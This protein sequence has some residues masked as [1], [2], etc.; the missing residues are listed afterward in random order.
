ML[1]NKSQ[2]PTCL[3]DAGHNFS[4][5]SKCCLQLASSC[6]T[7]I[8]KIAH[9]LV[10]NLIK[11]R[12][13]KITYE[14][15]QDHR[16]Y[17][18]FGGRNKKLLRAKI[19]PEINSVKPLRGIERVI[20]SV[21]HGFLKVCHGAPSLWKTE[22]VLM[23]S[24]NTPLMCP[25]KAFFVNYSWASILTLHVLFFIPHCPLNRF[26]WNRI[27]CVQRWKRIYRPSRG[28]TWNNIYDV[29]NH[30]RHFGQLSW[31]KKSTQERPFSI[32]IMVM[33]GSLEF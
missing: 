26:K 6:I 9:V 32:S 13:R 2:E 27:S 29:G 10:K 7:I 25:F 17:L 11:S 1:L 28:I 5:K 33:D 19:L 22:S 20:F 21:Y 8:N 4:Q 3:P 23:I 16:S 31:L 30:L 15:D 14:F 24:V 18:R 12:P